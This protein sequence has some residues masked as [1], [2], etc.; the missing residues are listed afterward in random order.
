[1]LNP[2]LLTAF[3]DVKTD[4]HDYFNGIL[5]ANKLLNGC[6]GDTGICLHNWLQKDK[7]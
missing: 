6:L 1:M 2:A 3:N 5:R 7:R 4:C